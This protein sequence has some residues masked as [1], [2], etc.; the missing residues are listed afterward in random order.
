MQHK[1]LFVGFGQIA[2][3]VALG[4][5]SERCIDVLKRSS[6]DAPDQFACVEHTF[7]GDISEA[8]TWTNV[9][10]NYNAILFCVTPGGRGAEAYRRVFYDALI[11]CITKFKSLK[12]PPHLFFVSSTSVYAQDD[13]SM[14]DE[15][16]LANGM[17]ETSKV[18]VQAENLLRD[19]ALPSTIIRFSGIY[20]GSRR[21]I[22]DQV[23]SQEPVLS[24]A[25]RRSN[26]IHEEDAV[27]FL[28]FLMKSHAQG[29]ALDELYV[30]TDDNPVDMNEVYAFIADKLD[31]SL[32]DSRIEAVRRRAGNKRLS[33]KRMQETGYQLKFP[34]FKEGYANM[35][36]VIDQ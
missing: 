10:D 2:S 23:L 34:S 14:V 15:L 11:H 18:L 9:P 5:E 29:Q 3:K 4:F 25:L 19:S 13:D 8:S 24:D 21:R 32:N 6:I 31:V 27:G 7:L 17:S 12:T 28:T 36:E 30:C 26:R 22:I 20:G 35:L 1:S 33:N 16:S